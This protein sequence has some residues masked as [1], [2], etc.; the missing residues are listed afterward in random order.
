LGDNILPKKNNFSITTVVLSSLVHLSFN[1]HLSQLVL[2][3]QKNYLH[4][5]LNP[6]HFSQGCG[7]C[8]C[9]LLTETKNAGIYYL[10]TLLVSKVLKI[11]SPGQFFQIC[12]LYSFS[13]LNE[14]NNVG[15]IYILLPSLVSKAQKTSSVGLKHR[16]A[17]CVAPFVPV[18]SP[19][20]QTTMVLALFFQ[21]A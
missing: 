17:F 20:E 8:S 4:Q 13:L 14:T 19:P 11:P 10:L 9:N 6:G 12:D 1:N 21:C 15:L 3:I 5:N 18:V 2:N 16:T 7:I